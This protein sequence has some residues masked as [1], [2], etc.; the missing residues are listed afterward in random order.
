MS[1]DG[2]VELIIDLA[3]SM[4]CDSIQTLGNKHMFIFAQNLEKIMKSAVVFAR[5]VLLLLLVASL[6]AC[7]AAPGGPYYRVSENP[8]PPDFRVGVN[9][10]TYV[11]EINDH[12]PFGLHRLPHTM[13]LL[14]NKG[15]D[16]VR[17]EREADF[18]VSVSF[19]GGV[20]D[21]PDV[22]AGNTVGG[23]LAGAAVGAIIGAA[24]GDPGAGAAIG[25]ASGGALGLVAPAGTNV[26]RIDV[27]LQ[28]FTE[29]VSSRGSAT[30]DLAAVPPREL[31]R[32]VDHEVARLLQSLPRR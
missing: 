8:A 27:D 12:T 10:Q 21:N 24:A 11:L 2:S 7:V 18:A 9:D 1:R 5:M 29:R 16:Q 28:S 3:A 4:I 14:Y 6:G 31:R 17:R 13:D 22:R 30:V 25:A 19:E 20:R 15:Y 32:V 23:A 26:L